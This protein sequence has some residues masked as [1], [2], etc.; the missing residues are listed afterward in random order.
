MKTNTNTGKPLILKRLA[1]LLGVILL[2]FGMINGLWFFGY[3][4]NYHNFSLK[5]EAQYVEGIEEADMLRYAKTVDGYSVTLKMPNYLGSGGF[6]SVEKEE[7]YVSQ[8]DENGN[9]IGDN[10][11][12]ITLFIWPQ[13]FGKYELG[14]DF[15]DEVNSIWEQVAIRPDLSLANAEDM[16]EAYIAY[17]NELI[18]ENQEEIDKLIAIAENTLDVNF[19]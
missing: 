16:D 7:G 10:G 3:R 13:Y 2:I 19:E 15:F 5:L 11:L 17:I 1:I 4:Q 18:S 9:I 12:N 14:L 6:I 8:L